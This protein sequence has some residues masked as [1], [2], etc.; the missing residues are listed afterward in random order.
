MARLTAPSPKPKR[1]VELVSVKR[2]WDSTIVVTA[3]GGG[4]PV[5]EN[6]D[7]SLT[8]VAAVIDKD[9]AAERLA[10]ELDVLGIE[11]NGAAYTVQQQARASQADLVIAATSEDEVNM[12]KEVEEAKDMAVPNDAGI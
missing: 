6:M 11:G 9:L 10:E 1:I 12:I 5:I 7:G 2:L 8:G 4:I 3:G